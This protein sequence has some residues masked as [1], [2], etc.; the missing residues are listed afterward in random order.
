MARYPTLGAPVF[1]TSLTLIGRLREPADAEAWAQ[2]VAP[3]AP[4]VKTSEEQWRA[5]I[6]V[7]LSGTFYCMREALPEMLERG[8]GRIGQASREAGLDVALLANG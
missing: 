4:L 3:S 2:F 8:F 5:A 6:E 1:T 7:N